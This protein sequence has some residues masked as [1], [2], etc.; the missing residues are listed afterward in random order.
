MQRK[1][2]GWLK[3]TR[4]S[5]APLVCYPFCSSIGSEENPSIQQRWAEGFWQF[6]G[7]VSMAVWIQIVGEPLFFFYVGEESRQRNVPDVRG[8]QTPNPQM[9]EESY[10]VYK[11]VFSQLTPRNIP[12][13]QGDVY[14]G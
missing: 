7:M 9:P 4:D 2:L 12:Q 5:C 3:R 13:P 11:K 14:R 6:L 8:R 1:L 10:Y